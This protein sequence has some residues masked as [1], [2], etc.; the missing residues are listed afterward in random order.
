MGEVERN[1]GDSSGND[2]DEDEEGA[3]EEGEG[4]ENHLGSSGGMKNKD[5]PV[6]VFRFRGMWQHT[7]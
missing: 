2:V 1:A 7:Y 6:H 4:R 5:G 3:D